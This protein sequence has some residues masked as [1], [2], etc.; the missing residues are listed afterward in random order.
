MLELSERD[1]AMPG[2]EFGAGAA[3]AM[4]IVTR[5][6]NVMEARRLIDV[7]SAHPDGCFYHGQASLDFVEPRQLG[8]GD[9]ARQ[10]IAFKQQ[11]VGGGHAQ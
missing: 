6:A 9:A 2:G 8:H 5:T 11:R 4:R 7:S 10:R 3:L 1:D